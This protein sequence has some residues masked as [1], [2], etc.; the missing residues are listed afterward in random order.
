MTRLYEFVLIAT[1]LNPEDDAF[2]DRLLNAGCDDATI[3]YQ[4]G[5]IL[6]DFARRSVSM[7]RALMSS[8]ADVSSSGAILRGVEPSDFVSLSEIARRANMT[9]AAISHYFA[10]TRASDFPLPLARVTTDSPLWSWAE[11]AEWLHRRDRV[12][13]ETLD[14][15]RLIAALNASYAPDPDPGSVERLAVAAADQTCAAA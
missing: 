1:G 14:T 11:V 9:R 15:A 5:L 13:Q 10:G 8:V 4:R 12:D 7:E 2:E 6:L 3:S